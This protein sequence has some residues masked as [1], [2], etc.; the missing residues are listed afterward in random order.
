MMLYYYTM[1]HTS[2]TIILNIM[3]LM[4]LVILMNTYRY[5]SCPASCFWSADWPAARSPAL[6]Q[7]DGITSCRR[8]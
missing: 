2:S 1:L 5:T 8:F 7:A 4:I 3:I 6:K